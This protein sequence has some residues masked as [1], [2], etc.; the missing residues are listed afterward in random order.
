MSQKEIEMILARQLSSYL[1]VPI[2][3]VDPDGTMVYFN[4]PA[5]SLLGRRFE[6]T[7]EMPLETWSTAFSPMDE[8]GAPFS[9][10]SL[11]LA[12]ALN[13]R[14]TNNARFWITGLDNLRHH[15]EVTAFPL[16]GQADRYLGAVALFWE[17][18][19]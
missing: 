11:P 2:F 17:L 15:I 8:S 3:I 16:I 10:E 4:R 6:E 1:A 7:R 13:K 12:V 9:P 5:E 18:P 19:S 14:Q